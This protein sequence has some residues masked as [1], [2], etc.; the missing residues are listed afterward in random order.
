MEL[1]T[2][3]LNGD[4]GP[5]VRVNAGTALSKNSEAVDP[6]AEARRKVDNMLKDIR[7]GRKPRD[8]SLETT[9]DLSLN[10]LHFKDFPALRRAVAKLTV[11]SKDQKLDVFFRAH[12]TAMVGTLNLYLDSELSY[13]WR[14]ASF[15]VSK[16]QGQG[17]NHARN[18]RTWIHQFLCHGKLPLHHFGQSKSSILEDE[19]FAQAI[20][21][22]LQGIAKE[23]YIRAQDIVD[24]VL[25]PEMQQKL[26][27]ANAKKKKISLRTAQRWLHRMG[28]RYGKKNGMYIDGHEREDVVKYREEFIEW[29]KG[30]EK[31]MVTYD[32][33]G[34]VASV[35]EG[36]PVAPGQPFKL[37]LVMHDESTYYEYDRRKSKW[38]H[39]ADKPVPER[40][41]EG[42][43]LMIS[44][45]LTLEWGRLVGDDM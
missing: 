43:S 7:E 20:Q 38:G 8:G 14:E 17:I 18:I 1:E 41:G 28:W 5:D 11:K 30:Y 39:K 26:D 24:Y 10:Q 23:G 36:F 37:I 19:D 12:I 15:V 45:F 44:D 4:Q 29:W 34:N 2:D 3:K 27:E 42:Q 32:N 31:R 13:T 9:T 6:M 40:K 21:L 22:H 16:S 35:L 25:T 33:D